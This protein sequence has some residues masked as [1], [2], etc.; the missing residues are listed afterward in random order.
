MH[1]EDTQESLAEAG[2]RHPVRVT[3]ARVERGKCRAENSKIAVL[4]GMCTTRRPRSAPAIARLAAGTACL[5]RDEELI[6]LVVFDPAQSERSAERSDDACFGES[7]GKALSEVLQCPEFYQRRRED[8]NVRIAPRVMPQASEPVE[9]GRFRVSH[10]H[11]FSL[12]IVPCDRE[13]QPD[14]RES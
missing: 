3:S 6:Q 14:W 9:L 7:A 11:C 8:R 5:G 2:R 1:R 10:I 13:H 4:R 12:W